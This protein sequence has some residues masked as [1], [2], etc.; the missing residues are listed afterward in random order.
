MDWYEKNIEEPLRNLVKL[1]RDNGFNTECSCGH[2]PNP[3]VQID[4]HGYD[5]FEIVHLYNLL[6]ENGY[7]NFEIHTYLMHTENDRN[8]RSCEIKF[9][10]KQRL[11]E[12]SDLKVNE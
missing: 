3:Y 10:P 9:Y 6:V 8:S 7:D 12:E 11:C 5:T 1:L 4:W 2:F